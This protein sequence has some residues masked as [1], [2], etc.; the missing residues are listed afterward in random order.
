MV[1]M[2]LIQSF[3]DASFDRISVVCVGQ[4][5][6]IFALLGEE[7]VRLRQVFPARRASAFPGQAKCCTAPADFPSLGNKG[8]P[9]RH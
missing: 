8:G 3:G 1:A 5:H 7:R 4:L 6:D 9:V 2:G